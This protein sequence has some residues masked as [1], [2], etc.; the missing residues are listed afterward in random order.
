MEM[1]REI[2]QDQRVADG[3]LRLRSAAYP[4]QLAGDDGDGV[5]LGGDGVPAPVAGLHLEALHLVLHDDGGHA[6]VAVRLQGD[7]GRRVRR[8]AVVGQP[9]T[10]VL[11]GEVRGDVVLPDAEA[12]QGHPLHRPLELRHLLGERHDRVT[13]RTPTG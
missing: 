8:R 6:V 1:E 12:L 3:E 11:R 5:G 2:D 7:G 4:E 9:D 13:G 10:V